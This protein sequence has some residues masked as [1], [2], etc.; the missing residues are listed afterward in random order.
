MAGYLNQNKRNDNNY[1]SFFQH[2]GEIG[3][4]KVLIQQC[5]I[6][7]PTNSTVSEVFNP[8]NMIAQFALTVRADGESL[9]PVSSTYSKSLS[10]VST[11]QYVKTLEFQANSCSDKRNGKIQANGYIKNPPRWTNPSRM[12]ALLSYLSQSAHKLGFLVF[13][14]SDL[15]HLEIKTDFKTFI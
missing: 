3:F 8:P 5:F 11:Y 4:F 13:S 14:G 1:C 15:V 7:C 10:H 12:Q 2:Q 6:C 9:S